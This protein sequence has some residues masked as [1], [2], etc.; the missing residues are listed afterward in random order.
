[1]KKIAIILV[2]GIA[3]GVF[4]FY[5]NK[6]NVLKN[7]ATLASV[8]VKGRFT[9]NNNIKDIFFEKY[10]SSKDGGMVYFR[11]I[12]KNGDTENSCIP[13]YKEGGVLKF[14]EFFSDVALDCDAIQ[15]FFRNSSD[16]YYL[17]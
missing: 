9:E 1:M 13:L 17:Y 10:S 8:L 6:K 15:N 14:K 16:E 2:I 11:V 7:E 5:I 12:F 3:I 4:F